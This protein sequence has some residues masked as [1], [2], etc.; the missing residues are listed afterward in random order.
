MAEDRLHRAAMTM[1]LR[2][3]LLSLLIT[4]GLTIGLASD[5]VAADPVVAAAGDIACDPRDPDFN[6]G[7]GSET[8]CRQLYTSDLLVDGQFAQVLALGD[9]Q[10]ERATLANFQASYDRSWGRVKSITRPVLGNHEGD[11]TGYFDYF[12]GKG[13]R[14]GPAGERGKGYY[15][16]DLGRWNLIALNSNCDRVS[17]KQGSAQERWLRADLAANPA[18]C[19]LAYWHHPRFSSGQYGDSTSMQAIWQDLYA[20]GVEVVLS[21]HSHNYERFAPQDEA[22]RLDREDGIRQFVVGGAGAFPARLEATKPNSERRQNTAFGLL[23]LTLHPTSYDWRFLPEAGES[24]QDSG[25][26][27]CHG[28]FE[29]PDTRPP[30]A[31]TG[32]TAS[33]GS[34]R[35]DLTWNAAVDDVGVTGYE[36]HRGGELLAATAATTF[37]DATVGRGATYSYR[38]RA[39]D[40]AGNRSAFSDVATVT[41]PASAGERAAIAP[42]AHLASARRARNGPWRRLT[43]RTA[44]RL[45]HRLLAS[46]LGRAFGRRRD[47]HRSCSR[48]SH[49]SVRCSVR[50]R[51]RRFT[52]AGRIA[53]ASRGA[54][55]AWRYRIARR[56]RSLRVSRLTASGSYPPSLGSPQRPRRRA[57]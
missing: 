30:G 23:E 36:I 37:S 6:D 25:S 32:L 18:S 40:A 38:V 45:V 11:G 31:P 44:K 54:R 15:S 34:V 8:R 49:T 19:T 39:L 16:F 24:F 28:G 7:R 33:A 52:Y 22:G 12:N 2:R 42:G 10:Y 57:L 14:F 3:L 9:L 20:A 47:Y 4:L 43:P 17:C 50:W 56:L 35:V 26:E 29:A 13:E 53:L 48:A 51:Y 46:R 1:S 5:A 55:I 21:G 41:T 27:L